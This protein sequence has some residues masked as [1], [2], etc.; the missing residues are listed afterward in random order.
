MYKLFDWN[1]EL[2]RKWDIFRVLLYSL[3]LRIK[4]NNVASLMI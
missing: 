4:N 3:E 2:F 1:L